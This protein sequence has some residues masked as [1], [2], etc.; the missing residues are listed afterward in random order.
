ME[1]PE[2]SE[3]MRLND[4]EMSGREAEN[5][6]I[7]LEE[8]ADCRRILNYLKKT[9]QTWRDDYRNPPDVQF[10]LLEEKLMEEIFSTRRRRRFIPAIAAVFIAI[11]G[12]TFILM[13][14]TITTVMTEDNGVTTE[15][16]MEGCDSSSNIPEISVAVIEKDESESDI[17][18]EGETAG[19]VSMITYDICF[20]GEA[21]DDYGGEETVEHAEASTSEIDEFT[22]VG[23]QSGE[24]AQVE[25]SPSISGG[26]GGVRVAAETE[27]IVLS[28]ES[29]YRDDDTSG[30]LPVSE[31]EGVSSQSIADRTV[32]GPADVSDSEVTFIESDEQEA[33][34]ELHSQQNVGVDSIQFYRI[35]I[36]ENGIPDSISATILDSLFWGWRD[37]IPFQMKDTTFTVVPDELESIL[38]P[39][40]TC[41]D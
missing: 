23:T 32:E 22:V 10:N 27:T 11:L 24:D 15:E 36:L 9:E 1:C 2:F 37:Y 18:R 4:G 38:L 19:T 30:S 41:S 39:D 13:N 5:L 17:T 7:H 16:Y 28:G 33:E 21:L 35:V 31:V 12:T 14:R 20:D 3:L 34:E 8:C 6:S 25:S 29:S 26:A 40:N